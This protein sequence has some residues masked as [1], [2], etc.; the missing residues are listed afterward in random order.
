MIHGVECDSVMFLQ[1]PL[2]I[3]LSE[4]QNLRSGDLNDICTAG[5]K[6]KPNSA[7]LVLMMDISIL[8]KTSSEDSLLFLRS[9]LH[10]LLNLFFGIVPLLFIL[11]AS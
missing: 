7:V 5:R 3:I 2:Q 8:R 10:V 6:Q 11:L 1:L 4:W 9:P